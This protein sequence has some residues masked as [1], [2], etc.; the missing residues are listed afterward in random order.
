MKR[1]KRNI[2]IST[3]QAMHKARAQKALRRPLMLTRAGMLIERL[4]RA[5]WPL[6]SWLFAIW[7]ILSF[8]VVDQLAIEAAYLGTLAS[9]AILVVLLVRG[10]TR[11]RWPRLNEATETLDR[12]LVGRPLTA[13]WDRQAIG[14]D[15]AAATGVWREHVARMAVVAAKARA[16][17]PDLRLSR[18]DPLGLRYVAATALVIAL[19]FGSIGREGGLGGILSPEGGAV[20]AGGPVYE[21]WIEPP[22]YTGLPAIYLNEAQ[23]DT[24]L[25]VPFGS[26]VTLRLYG[27]AEGMGFEESISGRPVNS[28]APRASAELDFTARQSGELAITGGAG[29]SARWQIEVIPD[30]PPTVAVTGPVDRSPLG[31]TMLSFRAADDYGVRGGKVTLKLELGAVDRRHGLRIPPEP[32]PAIVL[33]LPLPFTGDTRDFTDVIVEDLS[34]HPWAGLPVSVLLSATD[35]IEQVSAAEP[36][37]IDLPGRRFFDPLAAAIVEQRRDLLWNRENAARIAQVLRTISY[38]PEDIFD[39][40]SAY[41]TL[42]TAIRRLESRPETGMSEALRDD[43]AELL[44]RSATEIEDGDLSDAEKRLK[45]AQE[46]LSEA[47]ENGATEAEIAELSED[48]RRAMQEYL[49]QLARDAE[50]NPDQQ[51]AEDGESQE[52]TSDQLQAMLDRIQ[53]LAREGRMDEAQQLLEQLRE[54][55]ENMRTARRQQGEGQG[56]GQ[57]SMRDLQDTLRQQQGLSDDAFRQLQEQFNGEQG[58]ANRPDIGNSGRGPGEDGEG[59]DGSVP[60]MQDLARRQE[61]LRQ[62]LDSQRQGLP[63]GNSEEGRAA[64]EALRRAEQEMAR[65]RDALQGDGIPEALDSQAEALQ[66]LREGIESLGREMAR[67]Q[68]RNMGRQGDQAGSPDPN[69]ERDPLGRQSG[70][71]GRIGSEDN[72]LPGQDLFLR[73]RELME[74]IR[75]RSGERDRPRL[76]LDYLERLL[77]RF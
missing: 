50:A 38:L 37:L 6:W 51:M 49:E 48:L 4:M 14:V 39:S 1:P 35:D 19:L 45:R 57:Q 3:T 47:L 34:R 68:N 13:L 23:A 55:M 32:R 28:D 27:L 41:L 20:R 24:P 54:M 73:S 60:G 76:E 17:A 44:W 67:N 12:S 30:Q 15:D 56:Q 9:I 10:L 46:R 25:P 61:A 31:E 11:F 40:D 43:V 42:R 22:R 75:R 16:V 77:D 63:D 62:L 72:I 29:I 36:E 8:G 58:Q 69:S 26:K 71:L 66:A 7:A 21:G 70:T 18:G 64:R 52:I 33:D 2:E 74:E 5:F 65:A 59:Q 53:E